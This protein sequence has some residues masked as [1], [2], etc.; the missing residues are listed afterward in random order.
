MRLI[1]NRISLRNVSKI[2]NR[3]YT[4]IQN[5]GFSSPLKKRSRSRTPI[6]YSGVAA[7]I[8]LPLAYSVYSAFICSENR[9]SQQ[10]LS[11][12]KFKKFKVLNK[13][14][15]NPDLFLLELESADI[16]VA[17]P[18]DCT[19]SWSVEVKNPLMQIA[20]HYTPMP[21]HI[22]YP[23]NKNALLKQ[24][25][26]QDQRFC[27]LV[28]KYATGDMTRFICSKDIGET[29][30]LRGPSV[31]C[32]LKNPSLTEYCF[33]TAGTGLVVPMQLFLSDFDHKL[34][35]LKIFQ[36]S[37]NTLPNILL[38]VLKQYQTGASIEFKLFTDESNEF[39]QTDSIPKCS[40]S[41][42]G[43]VCGPPGYINYTTGNPGYDGRA[44]I[45]G[46]LRLGG[47][48]SSNTVRMGDI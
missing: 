3:P 20:R 30:E 40:A 37:R 14:E 19:K 36:S 22:E 18:W 15:L 35:I 4:Q 21:M 9:N 41:S 10:A 39:I 13:L 25:S 34:P 45:R 6:F 29:L 23:D 1:S 31:D 28:K 46:I 42:F 38:Q 24:N 8:V 32:I 5:S 2:L 43:I 26:P 33:F 27:L 17:L 44:P 7:L 47:W 16:K 11:V 12:D 48:D